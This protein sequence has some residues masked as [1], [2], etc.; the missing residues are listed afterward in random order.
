MKYALF[1]ALALLVVSQAYA[2]TCIRD[3]RTDK[4]LYCP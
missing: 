3:F 4:I 1:A 2:G